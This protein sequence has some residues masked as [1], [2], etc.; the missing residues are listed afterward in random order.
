MRPLHLGLETF[1]VVGVWDAFLAEPLVAFGTFSLLDWVLVLEFG[2]V[3]HSF[4]FSRVN[5]R[6]ICFETERGLVG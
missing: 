2:S 1:L 3:S 5:F 6:G 4:S